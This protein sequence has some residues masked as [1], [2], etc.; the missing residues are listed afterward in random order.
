M[1]DAI[2]NN[3][4][5]HRLGTPA[6]QQGAVVTRFRCEFLQFV[7]C[8]TAHIVLHVDAFAGKRP[9]HL[10]DHDIRQSN[11]VGCNLLS[12]AAFGRQIKFAP[13]GLGE[14]TH[15]LLRPVRLEGRHLC[16]GQ[17]GQ[18]PQQ[19]KVGL[20]GQL[21]ARAADFDDNFGTVLELC[22]MHLGNRRC[23]QRLNV[24]T[25]KDILR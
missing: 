4:F 11:H 1:K 7:T 15:Q 21:N 2:L 5:E 6:C 3:H 9:M 20:Y 14:F 8:N 12:I 19:A 25:C 10:G 23:C 24:K 17:V 16:L 18:M 13:Q 22:P